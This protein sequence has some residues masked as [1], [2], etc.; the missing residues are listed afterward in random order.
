MS[1]KK[2]KGIEKPGKTRTSLLT[3]EQ[4]DER[5]GGCIKCAAKGLICPGYDRTVADAFFL[6]E[7]AS[8]QAKVRK[9]KAKAVA[10]R[11]F[12]D[13]EERGMMVRSRDSTPPG[14][15]MM[16]PLVD[17]GI[18]FFLKHHTIALDQPNLSS[19]TYNEHLA[20]DGF[21]PLV[22]TTM[23]ALGLAGVANIY[24]DSQ[25]QREAMKWYLHAIKMANDAIASPKDVREDTTLVAVNLL[26]M[27]EATFNESSLMGWSS[28]VSG[29][30]ML[31]KM[32]GR[33]QF[34]TPAGRRMYLHTVG[35]LTT[36]CMGQGVALPDY[37]RDLN[38]EIMG[39]LDHD[40]PRTAFFFLHIKANDLRAHIINNKTLDLRDIIDRALELDTLAIAIFKGCPKEW[41][42]ETVICAENTPGVFGDCYHVYDTHATGQTWNWVRYNRIY[43]HDIIRNSILN[44]LMT[45]PPTLIG[46]KY[47]QQLE[48]STLVLRQVQGDILASMPQFLHDT[49]K[50][51]P[52]PPI[53]DPQPALIS[54]GESRSNIPSPLWTPPS[55]P[56]P[57]PQPDAPPMFANFKNFTDN[58]QNDHPMNAPFS[59]DRAEIRDR[60]PVVR[61]S[62][63]YSTVWACY[64]AGAMPSASPESQEYVL[65][66]LQRIEAEFGI[67]QAKVFG[68]A[69]KVRRRLKN[70]G[71]KP[72][73]ICPEYLPS[74]ED[75]PL[76]D[77]ED[78]CVK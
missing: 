46:A 69:L 7:T 67:K 56:Q 34:A 8:V 77:E 15:F 40:D 19:Q 6:D 30:A 20:T 29:A 33:S 41:R 24:Q 61:V 37:V 75:W 2:D 48:R 16:A 27:F 52:K 63:G 73:A 49:P 72:F 66:C 62:G 71:E 44:G 13:L 1:D 9:A 59:F 65:R 10:A 45:S 25:L 58:F 43:L 18:N 68:N 53:R 36:L 60:L 51:P 78:V 21:H 39:H 74:D 22:A 17:Q 31:V 64:I 28:H 14:S 26:T 50:I 23:T 11:E 47:I 38:D 32:R 42:Y 3:S 12:Q 35:L 5:P 55:T 70:Q 4:C 76:A 57:T 54:V